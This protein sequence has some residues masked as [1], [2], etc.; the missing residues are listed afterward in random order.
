M[1][2]GN[3]RWRVPF[4]SRMIIL[5]INYGEDEEVSILMQWAIALI[6]SGS[7]DANG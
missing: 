5:P 4:K 3:G 7:V 2:D 6:E 1:A